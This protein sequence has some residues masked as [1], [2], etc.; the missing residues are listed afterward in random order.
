MKNKSI[1][2]SFLFLMAASL[3]SCKKYLDVEPYDSVSDENTIFDQASAETAVRGAYRSLASNSYGSAFQTT[4]LLSGGDIRSLNNAQTD[5]NTINYDL[6]SDIGFL[7]TFWSNGYNT[8]NRANHVIEKVPLITDARLTQALKD[9]LVGEAYFIRAL[10]YF[11]L[12]RLFGNAQIFLTPTKT[13]ADKLGV[14]QSAQSR[15][16]EQAIADLNQAALLLPNEIV[17]NRARKLTAVALRARVY[18]YQ[19]K[20]AEAEADASTVLSNPNYKLIKPF[21]L[22]AGTSESVLELSFSVDAVNAG[23]G[24]WNTSNRALEPKAALHSLLNDS[25]IGGRR[26]ILSVANASGQFIG[27]IFPTNTA[28]NYILRTA[29]LYLIR[30]EARAQKSAPDLIGAVEDLNAVRF[31]SAVPLTTAF[32]KEDILQGIENERR[33]EFALEPFRWFDLVR[34]GRAAAVLGAT[35]PE[36]YIFPIPAS[37]ILADPSLDQNPGY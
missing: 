11:D 16:Y 12:G 15:I 22:A 2:F 37:E 20:Y 3:L 14:S 21:A 32:A 9:Q 7:S 36:K 34:T 28:A 1:L 35:N 19:K 10:S 30:A 27:G 25:T 8:I 29:E 24:L 18:L 23:F 5:L 17:R 4:V 6:R 13:V 26:K 31:R 33:V